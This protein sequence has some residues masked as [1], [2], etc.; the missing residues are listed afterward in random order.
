MVKLKIDEIKKIQ[1]NILKEVD[2]FCKA[3]S[4]KYS[5]TYGT[6]IGAIRHKGYIPWDDDID[7]MM[8]RPD[9]TKFINLFNK[10]QKSYRVLSTNTNKNH[11]YAYAKVEDTNTILTE[12]ST[13]K[14]NIGV[15][16]DIFP[17]DG[18]PTNP[19]EFLKHARKIK[20]YERLMEIKAIKL[21]KNR[22]LIKN[23]I[24]LVLKIST[25]FI[26][27][28]KAIKLIETNSL[29]YNYSECKFAMAPCYGINSSCHTSKKIFEKFISVEFENNRYNAIKEYDKYLKVIY[30]D[31]LK[32]P[33]AEQQV[34]HHKYK[35]FRIESIS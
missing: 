35:T 18:M 13:I 20:R 4:I 30:G 27:Y 33:P 14:Y 8:P 11:P 28:Q 1:L 23:I 3:N 32:L 19:K 31:Y 22:S 6:L 16:I 5:L 21:N 17:I 10:Q 29:K 25:T 24:L 15:N 26:S 12:Y 9:Y 34:S 7:I 2:Q